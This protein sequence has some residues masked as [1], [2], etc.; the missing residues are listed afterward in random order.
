MFVA[1]GLLCPRFCV[2]CFWI[3]TCTF[4]FPS[5]QPPSQLLNK[6]GIDD[7][8]EIKWH[9]SIKRLPGSEVYFGHEYL[10][11]SEKWLCKL[12][13]RTH[14]SILSEASHSVWRSK[15]NCIWIASCLSPYKLCGS[16]H[17]VVSAVM[18]VMFRV[19]KVF[20]DGETLDALVRDST[21]LDDSLHCR[22]C[23]WYCVVLL[24]DWKSLLWDYH[25]VL[26]LICS[27]KCSVHKNEVWI[28]R[29]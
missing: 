14:S 5:L 20:S 24:G 27:I 7:E 29:N 1:K 9:N 21:Y 26:C 10:P 6:V 16:L 8:W 23:V 13:N 18:R 17:S 28:P 2:L 4:N 15:C 25:S 3:F 11:L 22:I 19:W 12:Q